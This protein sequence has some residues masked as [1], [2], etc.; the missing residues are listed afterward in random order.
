VVSQTR[1]RGQFLFIQ[2]VIKASFVGEFPQVRH[3]LLVKGVFLFPDEAKGVEVDAHGV[4][5]RDPFQVFRLA[6]FQEFR[7]IAR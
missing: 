5:L 7:E 6:G 4:L 1:D 2:W 3:G